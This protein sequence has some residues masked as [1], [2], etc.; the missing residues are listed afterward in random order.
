MKRNSKAVALNYNVFDYNT[1]NYHGIFLSSKEVKK[2]DP[3]RFRKKHKEHITSEM[4]RHMSIR[5]TK[6]YFP[7]RQK[8]SDYM[9]NIIKDQLN[10]LRGYWNL[11]YKELLD[12]IDTPKERY[13]NCVN[14][15]IAT[16]LMNQHERKAHCKELFIERGVEHPIIVNSFLA[17][18]VLYVAGMLEVI[19]QQ[20]LAKKNIYRDK[21]NRKELYDVYSKRTNSIC[22]EMENFKMHDRFMSLYKYIKHSSKKNFDNLKEKY[23]ELLREE[24]DFQDE[25]TGSYLVALNVNEDT[26]NI[27]IDDLIVFFEEYIEKAFKESSWEAMWNYGDYFK[28]IA[29]E[30]FW[31]GGFFGD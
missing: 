27:L 16:P 2:I 22:E 25:M 1:Y 12:N 3:K 14:D 24:V 21:F 18:N 9:I 31:Y 11:E 7:P 5:N 4:F 28:S 15:P 13:K 20:S 10:E 30:S 6:Y 23:P 17:Q 26:L 8:R 19:L 29:K